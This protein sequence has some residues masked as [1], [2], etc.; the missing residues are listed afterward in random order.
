MI[1][2][3][4]ISDLMLGW[5]CAATGQACEQVLRELPGDQPQQ[6]RDDQL[7]ALQAELSGR[8]ALTGKPAGAALAGE[9]P[10][11]HAPAA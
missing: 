11:L 5:L 9:G 2:G 1:A 8:F 6:L 7:R 10:G 4:L 3:V